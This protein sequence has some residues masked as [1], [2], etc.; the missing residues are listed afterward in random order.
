[1]GSLGV[2]GVLIVVLWVGHCTRYPYVTCKHCGGERRTWD[3]EHDHFR[4]NDCAWCL[5]TG[6][7]YRWELR[8]LT[9]F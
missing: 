8:W 1:M 5:N 6:Y 9:L 2:I 7:R 3:S 4:R